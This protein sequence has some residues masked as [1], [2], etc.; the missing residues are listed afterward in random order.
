MDMENIV[1]F[2]KIYMKNH[3]QMSEFELQDFIANDPEIGIGK[4]IDIDEIRDA[5]GVMYLKKRI[6]NDFTK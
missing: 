3:E 5:L 4:N 2:A 1:R 6:R